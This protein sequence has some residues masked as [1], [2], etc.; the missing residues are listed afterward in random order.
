M[1]ERFFFPDLHHIILY[2]D[3]PIDKVWLK[4]FVT[5]IYP[6]LYS[7]YDTQDFESYTFKL[8]LMTRETI[9]RKLKN[10]SR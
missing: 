6:Q 10:K 2:G 1:F 5:E 3:I 8:A 4:P 7:R 9:I